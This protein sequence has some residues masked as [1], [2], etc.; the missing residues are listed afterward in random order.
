MS[1]VPGV[2]SRLTSLWSVLKQ[3][4]VLLTLIL[5]VAFFLRLKGITNSVT[6]WHAFRQADTASVTREYVRQ[7]IDLLHPRYH[8]FSN[9]ASGLD[10]LEGYRMVE[11][12]IVNAVV[13]F[14]LRV[15]PSWDLV[16]VSRLASVVASLGTLLGLFYLGKSWSGSWVGL[17]A[18]LVFAILPYSVYYSR[19]ILPEPFLICAVTW[20][21]LG[22]DRWLQ[23][24]RWSW[25][26]LSLISLAIA[27]LLKPFALFVGPVF[28]VLVWQQWGWRAVFKWQLYLFVV[29][30]VAPMVA[31][32]EWIKQFPSGIPASDWLFNGDGIR[33]RPAWF[34]W[35]GW[36]RFTKLILGG[37]GVPLMALGAVVPGK[38]WLRYSAW[39]VGIVV[40]LVVIATGNV[41]HDYYQVFALPIICLSVARG[42]VWLVQSVD[43]RL[44]N[45]SKNY[46]KLKWIRVSAGSIGVGLALAGMVSISDHYVRG[47][48]S[49]RPDWETAGRAAAELLPPDAVVI[50][51]A[52][53]DTAFLFQTQRRGW[54]IGFELTDKIEKGAEYYVTTSYDDE[55]RMV[56][57]QYPTI[58]KTEEY[59]LFDLRTPLATDTATPVGT[60]QE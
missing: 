60:T 32:R 54:P 16:V 58:A 3:E 17:A 34:R 18:A 41:R 35:L 21:I 8:D 36:E 4:H 13:A 51:P 1:Q 7:G 14:L 44:A 6:D 45:R 19:V 25:Y 38:E 46:L 5:I 15:V 9:I 39:W 59:L 24:R 31:W 50:A 37:V 40:Y 23:T 52:F 57:A 43:Q 26:S 47:Y 33:L 30:A 22:F 48:Y 53:G 28:A 29:A 2:T 11:F 20:S 55:A 12:P 42:L 49:T 56:E 27:L 10:N